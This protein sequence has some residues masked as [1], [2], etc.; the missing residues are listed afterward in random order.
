VGERWQ[1]VVAGQAGIL[2]GLLNIRSL[3][4]FAEMFGPN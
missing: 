1:L 4:E 3:D 2:A